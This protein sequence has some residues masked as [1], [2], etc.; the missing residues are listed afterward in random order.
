MFKGCTPPESQA[1][2]FYS[3]ARRKRVR[4]IY[5]GMVAAFDAMVGAY[6][7]AVREA[8]VENSTVFIITA[9]H[10]DM[11]M[12]HQQHYKMV[13]YD[14]SARV[15]LVIGG[16]PIQAAR[17]A[18]GAGSG[19]E[20]VVRAPTQLIDIFPTVLE[21][22]GV[23]RSAWPEL[24][25]FSLVPLLVPHAV[26]ERAQ[27]LRLGPRLADCTPDQPA[28][29]HRPNFVVSQFHG[30]NLAMSWYLAR[31]ERFK[32]VV[33]G[34]GAEVPPQLFD[35]EADPGEL[36]DLCGVKH[37]LH[38][39]MASPA[40][41]QIF[42][43]LEQKIREEVDYPEV[44]RQVALYNWESFNKWTRTQPGWESILAARSLRWHESWS[45]NPSGALAAIRHWNATQGAIRACRGT[46]AAEAGLFP[47]ITS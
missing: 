14:P 27:L 11:A 30:D 8:G 35:M 29:G 41:R 4:R 47:V 39:E 16:G 43:R 6:M 26:N 10:G 32:L 2:H 38:C 15:P 44:S 28:C 17:L 13:P 20:K 37:G 24:D 1:E 21:L 33:Y 19:R 7:E 3:E 22:A 34:T 12:E 31:E 36:D 9:D 23:P 5:Y 46:L 42:R 25:G 40:V 45:R 18:S